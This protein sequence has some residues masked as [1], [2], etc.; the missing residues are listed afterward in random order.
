MNTK[1]RYRLFIFIM[2]IFILEGCSY[3]TKGLKEEPKIKSGK[4]VTFYIT[5]DTHY[6]SKDLTD[7]GAA[8]NK[9]VLTGAGKQIGYMDEI[10]N[11]FTK[12]VKNKKPDILIISGDLTS[13][14]E[15]KSH[16]DIAKKLK[17]IEKDGTSVYVI[18]GNHDILNPWARGFKGDKQYVTDSISAKDFSEI[19]SEFGYKEA[20]SR[21]K[22]TLSYL[23]MPSEDVWLLM[24]DTNQYKNN[25]S[26]GF[27]E[28][29][30]Q[31]TEETYEW[32]KKCSTLAK[33]KGAKIITVMHHSLLNHSDV[34]QTGYTLNDNKK[35]I[36]VFQSNKLDLVLSGH[37][38]IQDI[39]SYKKDTDP[40]YDIATGSLAVYPHQ[41]GILKYSIKYTT[42]RYSTS[43][44]DVEGF[45]KGAGI[46]D[47]N[48]NNFSEYSK[49]FFGDLAYDM[50]YKQLIK[51][52]TYSK[53]E[54]KSMSETMRT[55]NLRYFAG[56]E[57]LNSKDV[58]NSEGFKLWSESSQGFFKK[59]I[60]SILKDKDTDDNNLKIQIPS[61]KP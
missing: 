22:N 11:A 36:D 29:D 4:D 56:T 8:F 39:S 45:S 50:A 7:N 6:L 21:D 35:A 31:I 13:N 27:P 28:T 2:L 47:K 57:D 3:A 59:Y 30:G 18:P 24:L 51:E 32:I 53:D 25:S 10:L 34:I 16:E 42:F 52:G 44:V 46:I 9:F 26:I 17:D 60:L 41:Y 37:I 1:K 48:I 19:Y 61:R 5:T 23:A 38:H 55:L 43:K 54:I 33:E 49:R 58:I 40:M 20:I 15:K 12:E 14:G